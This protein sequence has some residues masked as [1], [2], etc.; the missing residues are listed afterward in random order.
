[1]S[2]ML[3]LWDVLEI[4]PLN[5]FRSGASSCEMVCSKAR[6]STFTMGV[7]RPP[8]RLVHARER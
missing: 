8:L 7:E 4:Q 6:T 5:G 3:Q 1:M 2:D